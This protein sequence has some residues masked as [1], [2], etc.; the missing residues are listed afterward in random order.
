MK[1]LFF[2]ILLSINTLILSQTIQNVMITDYNLPNE[3]SIIVNPANT[4]NI[5]VGENS[6]SYYVSNDGGY[7]WEIGRA[8][9]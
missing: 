9:V 8:H 5:V 4:Q 2:L 3:P 7:T 6:S 1:H